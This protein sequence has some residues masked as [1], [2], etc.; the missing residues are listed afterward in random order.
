LIF[1]PGVRLEATL[2]IFGDS[3]ANLGN[4]AGAAHEVV[5]R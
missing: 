4:V 5:Q 2:G 3:D 1:K